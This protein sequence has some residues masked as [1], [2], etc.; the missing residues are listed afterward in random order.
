MG[1]ADCLLED[2]YQA[3]KR[4][5]LAGT[6]N[7]TN[8]VVLARVGVS[9]RVGCKARATCVVNDTS[10]I[11][12]VGGGSASVLV[13]ESQEVVADFLISLDDNLVTLTNVDRQNGGLV[14]LDGHEVSRNNSEFVPVDVELEGRLDGTVEKLEQ[15]L[16][17]RN[18]FGRNSV[19]LTC[20]RTF[21]GDRI[22][23]HTV[24]QSSVHCSDTSN[25]CVVVHVIDR[26]MR[27]VVDDK[28]AS[29]YIV[30]SG[31]GAVNVHGSEETLVSLESQVRVVPG[32][33][34]TLSSP[35]VG[36]ALPRGKSALGKTDDTI[37]LVGVVLS[38][39]VPMDR[40]SVASH[41]VGD[42]NDNLITP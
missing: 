8:T 40:S 17:A 36:H 37:H 11:V 7:A 19:A 3:G 15:V 33:S 16:L 28:M 9:S 31:L 30:L 20:R 22:D 35:L 29:I 25:L 38:N 14:R 10:D 34:V 42:V 32:E 24:D 18:K 13:V 27:P 39:T 21:L 2:G 26:N 41:G 5:V 4:L 12:R 6:E 1:R 23:V